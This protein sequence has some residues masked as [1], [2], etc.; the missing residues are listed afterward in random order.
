MAGP[1]RIMII[2]HGEK[3]PK[4]GGPPYGV[5][6]A[7]VRDLGSLTPRGWQRAGALA[8][9]F[10]NPPRGISKPDTIF[11]AKPKIDGGSSRPLETV[12]PL[13]KALGLRVHSN[14]RRSQT[15]AL[16]NEVLG[17]SGSVLICWDHEHIPEIARA[18]VGDQTR[19]PRW[20]GR[21]F[22]LIWVFDRSRKTYRWSELTQDLL[23][24]D[25]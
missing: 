14:F 5:D 12:Q 3:P 9:F 16:A 24:G 1:G 11:A 23:H 7:G 6:A 21:R 18:I 19:L 8:S 15:S 22:D 17:E 13:A 20:S 25:R 2:R 4:S 10:L